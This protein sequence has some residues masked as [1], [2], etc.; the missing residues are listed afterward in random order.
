MNVRIFA[1][2]GDPIRMDLVRNL[3]AS[4][5]K[6]ATQL[7]EEYPITRQG[8]LKHLRLLEAVG[9]VSVSPHGREKRYRLRPEPLDEIDE[10]VKAT[11]AIWDERLLR[12]KALL[13]TQPST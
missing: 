9:L 3:A 11:T 5:S 1:A 4:P 2:L 6:S 7:A 10:W 8:L 12:L 13:E